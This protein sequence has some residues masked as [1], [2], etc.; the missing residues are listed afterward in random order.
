MVTY[1]MKVNALYFQRLPKIVSRV[2]NETNEK[3]H[4]IC[5]EVPRHLNT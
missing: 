4:W 2:F 1:V 5:I 3:P